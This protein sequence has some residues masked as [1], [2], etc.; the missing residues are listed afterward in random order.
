MRPFNRGRGNVNNMSESRC[1][2]IRGG[3]EDRPERNFERFENE[4]KRKDDRSDYRRSTPCEKNYNCYYDKNYR[5][6]RGSLHIEDRWKNDDCSQRTRRGSGYF[7]DRKNDR[8]YEYDSSTNHRENRGYTCSQDRFDYEDDSFREN[9]GH[10]ERNYQKNRERVDEHRK[11][12]YVQDNSTRKTSYNHQETLLYERHPNSSNLLD[13]FEPNRKGETFS[14][15]RNGRY[16]EENWNTMRS[17]DS[18][19]RSREDEGT[20]Q[21]VL[22]AEN[23]I[24]GCDWSTNELGIKMAIQY[25]KNKDEVTKSEKQGSNLDNLDE[26]INLAFIRPEMLAGEALEDLISD[27]LNII[28]K[29]F[30]EVTIAKLEKDF[31]SLVNHRFM[32]P[33]VLR[34]FL[35]KYPQIFEFDTDGAFDEEEGEINDDIEIVRAKTVVELCQAHSADPKSCNGDC[36]SLHVCKFYILSSCEMTNCKFGHILDTGHNKAVRR[37]FYLHHV[38]LNNLRLLLRH[39]ANRCSVTIP[40]VCRFYNGPRGCR[41]DENSGNK[42]QKCPFLHICQNSVE[43]RCPLWSSCRL[44]HELFNI[45]AYEILCKYGLDPRGLLNGQNRVKTLLLSS[46]TSFQDKGIMKNVKNQYVPI[47]QKRNEEKRARLIPKRKVQ[48]GG[49]DEI[50]MKIQKVMNTPGPASGVSNS[51]EQNMKEDKYESVKNE[52]TLL[53]ANRMIFGPSDIG[54]DN[55]ARTREN[56][57]FD[58]NMNIADSNVDQY[59]HDISIQNIVERRTPSW[60]LSDNTGKTALKDL[61]EKYQTYLAAKTATILVDGK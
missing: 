2:T 44:N 46:I 47:Q 32:H 33:N 42:Q 55:T 52:N 23:T 7:L 30:G 17:F 21:H 22:K 27:L 16:Q 53:N 9:Y 45:N 60:S 20:S 51:L 50:S 43:G 41:S 40:I 25:L 5:E 54:N 39:D 26:Q 31:V 57:D 38:D 12:D 19:Q 13:D 49:N 59:K 36:N 15:L 3:R 1:E 18:S 61:E 58:K 34:S 4:R 37:T 48:V 10:R 14:N 6:R 8:E 35:Q 56:R 29:N 24:R 28:L 11:Q